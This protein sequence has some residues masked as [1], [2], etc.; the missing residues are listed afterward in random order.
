MTF[1]KHLIRKYNIPGPRYT[2]Y[3]TVPYWEAD[4]FS[5]AHWRTSVSEAF[6]ASNATEGISMYIHL[7]FC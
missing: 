3:P 6:S 4:T 2:S 5:E 7:P 1:D